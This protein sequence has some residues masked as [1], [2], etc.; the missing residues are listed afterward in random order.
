VRGLLLTAAILLSVAGSAVRAGGAYLVN[1]DGEPLR[2]DTSQPLVFHLD[3]LGPGAGGLGQ[4]AQAEAEALAVDSFA[5]WSGVPTSSVSFVPGDSLPCD[6]ALETLGN[7]G[8]P[9][10]AIL[11]VPDDGISPV[12]FDLDGSLIAA[13]FGAPARNAVIGVTSVVGYSFVP[14]QISDVEMMLN[15]RFFDGIDSETNPESESQ[16]D[17]QAVFVHEI[18]HWVNLDHSQLNHRFWFDGDPGNDQFLP[19]MFPASGDDD[20]QLLTLNPDDVA[21]LSRLYPASGTAA[22]TATIQGEIR[23]PDGTTPFQGANLVLRALE[24][25]N[26]H[27]YSAVSGARYFPDVPPGLE[28]AEFGGPAPDSLIGLFEFAALPA[29]SYTLQV[30][31]IDPFFQGGS[32]VGPFF[33]PVWVP[34]PDEFF[35]GPLEGADYTVDRPASYDVLS[36]TAGAQRSGVDIILNELP[37]PALLYA[38]DDNPFDPNNPA[39]PTAII[40]LDLDT[41]SILRRIPA[42]ETN[43]AFWEG[44]AFAPPRGTLF[45]TDNLGSRTIY[46]LDIVDGAILNSF[47]WPAAAQFIDGLAFLN[48]PGQPA[49]GVL[50]ALDSDLDLIFGLSPDDGTP[51]GVDLDIGNRFGVNLYGSLGGS[52]DDLFVPTFGVFILHLRPVDPWSVVN[53]FPK[54]SLAQFDPTLQRPGL[55]QFLTGLGF[56]GESLYATSISAPD[57]RIWRINPVPATNPAGPSLRLDVLDTQPDPTPRVFGGFSAAAVALRGDLDGTL[58]VDGFDL[59]ALARVFPTPQ[60]D[61]ISRAADLDRDSDVDGDDLTILAAFFGRSQLSV[62]P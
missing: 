53:D 57:Y 38:V 9:G 55:D 24:D 42:P 8:E 62:M 5:V 61:D 46:E 50:Y 27:V 6:L 26:L 23:A 34:G 37:P 33:V 52:G 36:V 25:P 41:G 4:L 56:D 48:G 31:E 2:W 10:R 28:R 51:R 16:D 60:V 43:S 1:G 29:G 12:V 17:F 3:G 45:F 19:T 15:G 20:A 22:S 35:N 11:G 7:C 40:E 21:T 47:A 32:S 58:R 44:L 54:P 39:G 18:G 14:P 49:G 13:L 59:A 30:Q